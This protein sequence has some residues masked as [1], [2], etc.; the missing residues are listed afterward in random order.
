ML[1]RL[2]CCCQVP[3][4]YDLVNMTWV[5]LWCGI[6]FTCC[7]LVALDYTLDAHLDNSLEYRASLT[8]VSQ[9]LAEQ[10]A[11]VSDAVVSNAVE[12]ARVA[13]AASETWCVKLL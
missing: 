3:Y 8:M 13:T 10:E 9:Q 1:R 5:G 11:V 7:L 2:L 4:Y 6:L 12:A